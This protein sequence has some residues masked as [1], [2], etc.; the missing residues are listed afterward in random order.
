[1]AQGHVGVGL[2]ILG[3]AYRRLN[4]LIHSAFCLCIP[5]SLLGGKTPSSQ[6]EKGWDEEKRSG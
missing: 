1:M 5:L 4:G 6:R 2:K 3:E